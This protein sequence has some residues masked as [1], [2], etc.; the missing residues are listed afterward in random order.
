M[1]GE[2]ARGMGGGGGAS[3]RA[4][5][6]RRPGRGLRVAGWVLLPL[7][8]LLLVGGLALRAAYP[9]HRV[10][11]E[12]MRPTY[13]PGSL[14]FAERV[15]PGEVRRGDVVLVSATEWDVRAED[16]FVKRVIGVGGDRVTADGR[17]LY[18]NGRPL[19]EPYVAGGD[20]IGGAPA[21]DVEVPAGRVFL[22]GDNR[23]NSLDSRY[24]LDDS[25]GGTLP[26]TA[27][28]ERAVDRPVATAAALAGT[29]GGVAIVL[30]GFGLLLAG[31][32]TG[33]RGPRR[34]TGGALPAAR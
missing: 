14:L 19:S 12:S 7:G 17:R 16:L 1:G 6:V 28:R 8:V 24:H 31:W 26:V 9:V 27:V 29:L 10:P 3:R 15:E 21:F 4:G 13:E 11:S 30:V 34:A 2:T 25:A 33:R 23:G 32:L 22:L 18:V 20:P 5:H